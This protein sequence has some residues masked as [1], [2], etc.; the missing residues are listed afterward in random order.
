MRQTLPVRMADAAVG[1]DAEMAPQRQRVQQ[2][3]PADLWWHCDDHQVLNATQLLS[4]R[5]L[6]PGASD[7]LRS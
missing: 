4:R 2:A 3:F 5:G 6:A 1:S 7:G